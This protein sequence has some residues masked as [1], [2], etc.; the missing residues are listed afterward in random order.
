[1]SYEQMHKLTGEIIRDM[2]MLE[3][4]K[5]DAASVS[6]TVKE[7]CGRYEYNIPGNEL[8]K[9]LSEY[10]ESKLYEDKM[11]LE[12]LVVTFK[13]KDTLAKEFVLKTPLT[14]PLS[15]KEH[16]AVLGQKSGGAQTVARN[17]R[18][19][20]ELKESTKG[21]YFSMLRKIHENPKT[22]VN[23]LRHLSEGNSVDAF[24]FAEKNDEIFTS[25]GALYTAMTVARR[26]GY[27]VKE[28]DGIYLLPLGRKSLKLDVQKIDPDFK[29]NK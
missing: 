24:V 26:V 23:F 27:V 17:F 25:R 1:M 16:L 22:F 20:S 13:E 12:R 2:N 28:K 9:G 7:D 4:L 10:F 19:D 11:A 18:K 5:A 3:T 14:V 8:V 21:K 6:V 15:V 29:F